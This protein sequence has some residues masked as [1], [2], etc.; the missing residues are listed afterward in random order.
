MKEI[1]LLTVLLLF[2]SIFS[3]DDSDNGEL[4]VVQVFPE[5]DAIDVSLDAVIE[6]TFNRALD[7][8]TLENAI[9]LSN[10]G[11]QVSGVISYDSELF[12]LIFKPNTVLEFKKEYV[13]ELSSV[14]RDESNNVQTMSSWSFTTLEETTPAKYRVTFNATWS[15]ATHPTDFPSNP[16][17]SGLIGMTHV[18]ATSL[19]EVGTQATVGIKNMAET[20][21]K[22]SLTTEIEQM[23]TDGNSQFLISGGGVS[24]SPGSVSTEFDINFSHP[25]VSVVSMIAPSP[26]WFISVHDLSL[27][28]DGKWVQELTES[29]GSYDSGT[30]SGTTFTSANQPTDPLENIFLIT[31]SPLGSNGVVVPLGSMTFTRI[32]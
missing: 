29:A 3:C 23:I 5:Q 22:N 14:I 6:V 7:Q 28:V 25:V 1:K 9:A 11:S 27:H 12:K 20:G 32:E 10:N 2:A 4:T 19:F 17:F 16:H 21:S 30:D 24:L 31:N 13:V 8:N 18:S 15:S 26:D